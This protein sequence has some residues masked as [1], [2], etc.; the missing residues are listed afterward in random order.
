MASILLKIGRI[1]NSQCRS[2]YLKNAKLFLNS[3]FHFWNQ[4]QSLNIFKTNMMVIADVFPKLQTVNNFERPPCK[5]HNFGTRFG[6]QHVKVSQILEKSPWGHFY[7][8]FLSFWEKLIGKMSP[9][10]L[11]EILLVF[12]NTLTADAKYP[13]EDWENLPL[14]IQM[15]LSQKQKTFS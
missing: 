8:V 14:P 3:L 13:I 5:K 10:L 4:Y 6:R 2:N 11:P 7:D 1:G 15:Q 12:L 9:L